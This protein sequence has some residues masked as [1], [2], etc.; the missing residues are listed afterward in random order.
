MR[1]LLCVSL[2]ALAAA[3]SPQ[4]APAGKEKADAAPT[5]PT[6]G[7]GVYSEFQ[8]TGDNKKVLN[9]K[10]Y[11]DGGNT[12]MEFTDPDKGPVVI[13]TTASEAIIVGEENGKKTALKLPTAGIGGATGLDMNWAT[14]IDQTKSTKLGPCSAAGQQGELWRTTEDGSDREACVTSDGVILEGKEAGVTVW[15]ATKVE[16]GP[17]PASLFAVPEGVEVIDMGAMMKGFGA[18]MEKLGKQLEA[19]DA[20]K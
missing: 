1:R 2:L 9:G 3:C 17:Q 19:K 5:A 15:Q 20:Q 6:A 14:M 18:E 12:R 11:R 13:I 7:G 8:L 10:L 4:G 16:R